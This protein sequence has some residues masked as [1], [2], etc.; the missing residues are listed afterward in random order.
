MSVPAGQIQTIPDALAAWAA[1]TPEAVALLAPDRAPVTYHELQEA[2]ERLACA[3]RSRGV[4]RQ[5]GIALLFPEGPELGLALLAAIATGIAVPLAWPNPGAEYQPVLAHRRVRAVLVSAAIPPSALALADRGLP[6]ITFTPGPSGRSGDFH[7]D[8][9][10][11]DDPALA[12]PAAEDELALILHSSGTTGRPKLTP[13]SHRAIVSTCRLIV[14]ARAI[15]A[16]DRCLV[17]A[18][19]AYSQGF[20][21]LMPPILAGAAVVSVP[22]PDVAAMPRW[23]ETFRP[24][25][26]STTPAVLRTLAADAKIRDALRRWPPRCIHVSSAALA[27]AEQQ[28]LESLFGAPILT[29]YGMSEATGIA[30]EPLPPM[31]R[32]PGSVGLP[33]CD[34]QLIDAHGD[35]VARGHHGEIVVRGE[36]VFPGYLDDPV[37]NA[38]AFLPGGWF[39]TGDVGVLDD[40]GHLHLIGR[41]DEVINRGGEKIVPG[42]I[43]AVLHGH[44]A[45]AEAAV[46]AV[47]DAGLGEDIVAAIVVKPGMRLRPW[48][49]RGWMLERLSAYKVPRR[50]WQVTSLPRTATGK[51]QRAALA[52]RWGEEQR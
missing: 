3:L 11:W 22:E 28:D 19:A 15:T 43:D 21:A 35:P 6:V 36:R 13:R 4:G 49:L 48:E 12:S 10:G 47:P 2:V 24:T 37:A 5:D 20:N 9:P 41:R 27:P 18:R 33:R 14:A 16:A 1:A 17:L 7:L 42:E 45:V 52:R 29:G 44:P 40:A 25:Y 34:L 8:G 51:V 31:R 26:C 23:L 46:F 39:R 30:M 38:A 50:I 32:V